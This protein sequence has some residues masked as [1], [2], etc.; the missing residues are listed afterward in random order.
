MLEWLGFGV[1]DAKYWLFDILL[2]VLSH[3]VRNLTHTLQ[4]E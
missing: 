2:I 4:I 1:F 3:I